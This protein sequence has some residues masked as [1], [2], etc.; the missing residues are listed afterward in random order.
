MDRLEQLEVWL[1][2]LSEEALTTKTE[3]ARYFD[4][5]VN[6]SS[7][8]VLSKGG[9]QGEM[10]RVGQGARLKEGLDLGNTL[11]RPHRMFASRPFEADFLLESDRA[12]KS[13][14]SYGEM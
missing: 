9:L 11:L 5:R 14:P 12:E 13:K 8:S 6:D 7:S 3:A 2:K 1:D 4:A 10:K